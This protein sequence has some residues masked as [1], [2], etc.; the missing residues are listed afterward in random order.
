MQ[1]NVHPHRVSLSLH[2]VL[3]AFERALY[4][5]VIA[6]DKNMKREGSHR[7]GCSRHRR[8]SEQRS[9]KKG[10]LGVEER[11]AEVANGPLSAGGHEQDRTGW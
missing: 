6:F 8:H 5:T 4:A 3:M 9:S 1:L 10:R 11:I 2:C 7:W